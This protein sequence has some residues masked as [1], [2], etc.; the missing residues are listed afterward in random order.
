LIKLSDFPKGRAILR[1]LV[2]GISIRERP[3]VSFFPFNSGF[4]VYTS[5]EID[6]V[7]EIFSTGQHNFTPVKVTGI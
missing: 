2:V 7:R 6:A 4:S 3:K 5:A 1:T